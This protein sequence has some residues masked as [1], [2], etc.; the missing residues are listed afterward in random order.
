LSGSG[1]DF[2]A[3]LRQFRAEFAAQL[4]VRLREAHERLQDCLDRPTNDDRLRALHAVVHRLAGSAGTFG[5]KELGNRARVIEDLLDDLL[6]RPGRTAADFAKVAQGI[7]SL[8]PGSPS[9]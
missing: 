5:M 3:A 8:E 7:Q 4:P 2:E 1:G 9:G 6:P